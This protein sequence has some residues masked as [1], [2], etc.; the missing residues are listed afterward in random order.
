MKRFLACCT[1][2]TLT[3]LAQSARALDALSEAEDRRQP[4]APALVAAIRSPDATV[5]ALAAQVY[6]R[7]QR[8]ASVDPLLRLLSDTDPSVRDRAAFAAGQLGWNAEFAG[9]RE[10]ELVDALI[11]L[12][13]SGSASLRATA[14]EALGK[15]GLLHTPDLVSLLLSDPDAGVRAEALTAL[16]RY[17][18]VL[19]LRDPSAP[20]APLLADTIM[21]HVLA[22]A[23]DP[24]PA[25]RRAVAYYFSKVT[26]PRGLDTLLVLASDGDPW[27]RFFAISALG[28]LADPAGR[29]AIIRA[30]GDPHLPTRVAA[31]QAATALK[32]P[33]LVASEADL[34]FH[35]RTALVQ[36]VANDAS[37]DP[38]GLD[39]ARRLLSADA[40]VTVRGEALKALVSRE[41]DQAPALLESTGAGEWQLRQ[42]AVEAAAA[43]DPAANES[44]L[45]RAAR[46]PDFHVRAAALDALTGV[47]SAGAYQAL[48]AALIS[49]ELSERGTAASAL[50]SRKESDVAEQAWRAYGQSE[51]QKWI[52]TRGLLV[53]A[54]ALTPGDVTT[55]YLRS[56]L[57]DPAA[58]VALEARK[59]LEAR[60]VTDLPPAPVVEPTFSPYRELTFTEPPHVVLRTTR[61]TLVIECDPL[62]API[63]VAN[64]VGY[65]RAGGYDGL[66][67]HRVV[68]NFVVQGGDP[69]RSGWGDAGWALRAEVNRLRFD[70]GAVGM[71]RGSDFDTGG[72]QLFINLVPTPHL[73]GQYT[74]FGH[75]VQG[76][77]VVDQLEVG[78]LIVR[79]TVE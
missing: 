30:A 10:G 2:A 24:D 15:L 3:I 25:V 32:L 57:A 65:A 9:G 22:L 34:S 56:A 71:P 79:A 47:E 20:A 14:V 45:L 48:T 31:L 55:A 77:D 29:D 13:R 72:I 7:I 12:T 8:P 70:R 38:A 6:G 5:R 33:P 50:L 66:P 74:V 42:A 11:L 36:M 52:E 53:D 27:I 69:D 21:G 75:V 59:S 26:D 40:S 35:A 60:G 23:V 4:D 41:P 78:D 62:A 44:F 67:W 63:H 58:L 49:D 28:R 64:F 37:G 73:D 46:D 76:M 54:I 16:Y 17:R 18:L 43:L 51:G 39:L 1:V 68:S 19:R 61:G